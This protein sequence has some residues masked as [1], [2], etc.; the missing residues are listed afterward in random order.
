MF[1]SPF[2]NR[3]LTESLSGFLKEL[4]DAQTI[5]FVK[6]ITT[7]PEIKYSMLV[8]WDLTAKRSA[9][10]NS[11]IPISDTQEFIASF[12]E[13]LS[14]RISFGEIKALRERCEN[15]EEKLKKSEEDGHEKL[16]DLERYKIAYE[17][18]K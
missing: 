3:D 5:D 2:N 4:L 11:K 1:E 12:L 6:K 10:L 18:N 7:T 15:L 14:K 9:F 8:A 17:M 16:K 13:E